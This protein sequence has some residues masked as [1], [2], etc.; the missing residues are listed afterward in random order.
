MAMPPSGEICLERGTLMVRF[1]RTLAALLAT[2][3]LVPAI[4]AARPSSGR[5]HAAAPAAAGAP[6][7]GPISHL[8]QGI[9]ALWGEEGSGWDPNG[10]RAAGPTGTAQ[11]TGGAAAV[12]G[13]PTAP[14]Q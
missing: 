11:A 9:R 4:A 6:S 13:L 2:L 10:V 1:H 3:V 14:T 7:A 8:W 5:V 12:M